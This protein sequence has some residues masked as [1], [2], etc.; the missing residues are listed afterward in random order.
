M[1]AVTINVGV[2]DNHD[3]INQNPDTAAA[4]GKEHNYTG[5]CVASVEPMDAPSSHKNA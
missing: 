5:D 3:Q 1:L 2:A 4:K